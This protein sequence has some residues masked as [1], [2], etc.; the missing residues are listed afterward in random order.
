MAPTSALSQLYEAGNPSAE[1]SIVPLQQVSTGIADRH[2]EIRRRQ[3]DLAGTGLRSD[4]SLNR[5]TLQAA[6]GK[7]RDDCN[8]TLID[9]EAFGGELGGKSH[10][11]RILDFRRLD[12]VYFQGLPDQQSKRG[13]MRMH[14]R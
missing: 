10:R 7:L 8:R 3:A 12:T 13:D 14:L 4:C 5:L 1:A 11:F 9:I 2:R 6:F